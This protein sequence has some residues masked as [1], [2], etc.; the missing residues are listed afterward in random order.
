M[1]L[2]R[3]VPDPDFL[4]WLGLRSA[5]QATPILE[6]GLAYSSGRQALM[7]ALD[8]LPRGPVLVS[9]Q[10]C[11][12]V[13]FA[14]LQLGF[15]PRFV[16]VDEHFPCP[17]PQQLARADQRG[18]VATILSPLYGL[19]PP[20]EQVPV[21]SP[22]VLDLA[23]GIGCLPNLQAGAWASIY[24]FG[25]GKGVDTGGGWCTRSNDQGSSLPPFSKWELLGNWL[26]GVVLFGADRLGLLK[27]LLARIDGA[28]EAD[29]Q[30]RP[31][32][33]QAGRSLS[34]A[35]KTLWQ[36]RC[37]RLEQQA[38]LARDRV[39]QISGALLGSDPD[40]IPLRT[41]VRVP[42]ALRDD[43]LARL[44]RLEIDALA[45]G[46]PLPNEYLPANQYQLGTVGDRFPNAQ[47]FTQEA[48]RLPFLGRLTPVQFDYLRCSVEEAFVSIGV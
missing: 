41:I 16:D 10:I 38:S 39:G 24:S 31:I 42:A 37:Q 43:L 9:A 27:H 48:V 40:W 33:V 30:E 26:K 34:P 1:F 15:I 2:P 5:S 29:K 35:L 8:P 28:V 22:L 45:A 4:A 11:P 25:L 17:G 13:P 46:E 14:L 44:H 21:S 20:F 3:Y 7:A 47:R 6:T 19:C 36:A 32:A 12:V 18:L 23:Q